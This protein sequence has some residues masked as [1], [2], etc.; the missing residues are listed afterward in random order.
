MY[1]HSATVQRRP[2]RFLSTL[3]LVW[4]CTVTP[5][6]ASPAAAAIRNVAVVNA[7]TGN[8][9]RNQRGLLEDERITHIGPRTSTV[10]PEG[11]LV[12][13]GD[14]RRLIAIP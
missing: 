9:R 2:A 13:E 6:V 4:L 5:L 12:V 7:E 11:V 1:D 3:A 10:V 14:V 8:P